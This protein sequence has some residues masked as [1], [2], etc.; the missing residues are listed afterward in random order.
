LST[1]SLSTDR[2]RLDVD[3]VHAALGRTYWAKDIG[4]ARVLRS[5]DAS[6]C[7]GM[8]EADRQLAFARVVTD[9]ATFAYL[10]DVVVHED[11]RGRG[12][13]KQLVASI[14]AHPELRDVRRFVL[15]TR[16]AHGLYEKFGFV[17]LGEQPGLMG[18]LQPFGYRDEE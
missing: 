2:G 10:C 13:G 1:L 14:V 4:R 5:L 6:L 11:A 15:W 12:L 8:Y 7:F 17:R 18:I 3:F 16:D 9:F